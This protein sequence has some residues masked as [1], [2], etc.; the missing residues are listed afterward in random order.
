MWKCPL[1]YAV[2][3]ENQLSGAEVVILRINVE[4]LDDVLCL[5]QLLDRW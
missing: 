5:P 4:S 1:V 2:M 3:F